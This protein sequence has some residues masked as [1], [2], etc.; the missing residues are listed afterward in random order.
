MSKTVVILPAYNAGRFLGKV[1]DD[2]VALHPDFIPLVID[3]GSSDN[4]AEV[5][6]LHN[7]KLIKHPVNKGKG[8]ALITG[9]DFVKHKNSIGAPW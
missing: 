9:F 2:I 3:D 8:A 6:E 1:I 4:T 7:A 5:A